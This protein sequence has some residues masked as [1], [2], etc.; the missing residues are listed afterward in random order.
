M[1]LLGRDP[2]S[3]VTLGYQTGEFRQESVGSDEQNLSRGVAVEQFKIW[4]PV[5]FRE[6]PCGG[7][8]QQPAAAAGH[9]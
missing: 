7:N 9:R 6:H 4:R 3:A 5:R 1:S 8:R 2:V